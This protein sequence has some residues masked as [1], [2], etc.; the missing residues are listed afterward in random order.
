MSMYV[1]ITIQMSVEPES[2]VCIQPGSRAFTVIWPRNNVSSEVCS[3]SPWIQI[4]RC[5]CIANSNF[6][7]IYNNGTLE[8]PQLCWRRL[9][10]SV[11]V[12]FVEESLNPL[13]PV[14]PI[15][16]PLI[17]SDVLESY[18]LK[19]NCKKILE[20]IAIILTVCTATLWSKILD[21]FRKRKH[22]IH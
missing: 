3:C 4:A 1:V 17:N 12:H 13:D 22:G 21:L 9:K 10:Y 5:S 8:T 15:P 18:Y 16:L 19:I 14:N 2:D 11:R 20:Q 7:G 6:F